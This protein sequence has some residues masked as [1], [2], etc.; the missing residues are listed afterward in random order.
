MQ[1]YEPEALAILASKKQGAFIVL[2]GKVDFPKPELEYREVH[3]AVL[4]QKRN[5][6]NRTLPWVEQAC[7]FL[8]HM[9]MQRPASGRFGPLRVMLILMATCANAFR[10]HLWY[11]TLPDGPDGEEAN[12]VFPAEAASRD[13]AA[14]APSLHVQP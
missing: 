2:E 5:G 3:G 14:A 6:T 10:R 4:A 8:F 11:R 12:R 13:A 9:S 1:G 7:S